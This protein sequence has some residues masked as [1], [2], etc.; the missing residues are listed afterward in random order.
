MLFVSF[1]GVSIAGEGGVASSK[2]NAVALSGRNGLAVS[3]PKA[4]AIA[5]VSPQEAA[6]FSVSVPS[7]NQLV[8]KSASTRL[9]APEET[10]SFEDYDY[11]ESSPVRAATRNVPLTRSSG[12]VHSNTKNK[13]KP[14]MATASAA[15]AI[16][17]M[18][19]TAIAEDYAS[20]YGSDAD[21]LDDYD[22][23][24][25]YKISKKLN[26]RRRI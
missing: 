21:R 11:I 16:V 14:M 20:P 3:A 24:Q 25:L 22:I 8:I 15:D 17:Q 13:L 26:K 7:R 12:L 19:R 23:E 10:G 1:T 9:S 2:P 6:A 5:G 18:W 4:T